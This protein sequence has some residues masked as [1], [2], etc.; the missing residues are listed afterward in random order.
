MMIGTSRVSVSLRQRRA[1]SAA[2]AG[3]H[4]VQQ[5]QVGNA[6]GDRGLG[7][8]GIAGVDRFVIALAKGEGDHFTDRGLVI[9]D[10]DAF[11]TRTP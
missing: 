1:R 4:P 2:G 7:L 6:I 9:D 8:P 3:Q 5:D 10:Q 11:C